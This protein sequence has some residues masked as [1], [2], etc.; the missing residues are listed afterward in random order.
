MYLRPGKFFRNQILLDCLGRWRNQSCQIFFQSV[1]SDVF[2]KGS[3]FAIFSVNH[4]WPLQ[5]LYYRTTV[6][7]SKRRLFNC[8]CCC[9]CLQAIVCWWEMTLN[10]ILTIT[11]RGR[12]NETYTGHISLPNKNKEMPSFMH[13]PY[14]PAQA[15]GVLENGTQSQ[16]SRFGELLPDPLV[17]AQSSADPTGESYFVVAV[18]LVYSMSVVMLIA[19]RIRRRRAKM[20]VDHQIDKYLREFQIVKEK[21]SRD[22]Y[23]NLKRAVIAKLSRDKAQT[24][25][26]SRTETQL[27]SAAT[28]NGLEPQICSTRIGL[29]PQIC[30][31]QNGLEPPIRS[32]RIGAEP[33]ICSIRNG[34]EPQICSTRN[35]LELPIRST[36]IGLEPQIC[37]TRNGLES[38]IRS[39]RLEPQLCSTRIGMG[40]FVLPMSVISFGPQLTNSNGAIEINCSEDRTQEFSSARLDCLRG[41]DTPLNGRINLLVWKHCIYCK[42]Y[43]SSDLIIL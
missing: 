1:H 11:F 32:T 42:F 22:S 8:V 2:G 27:C 16:P 14:H 34:L 24:L 13:T 7:E 9:C 40:S 10:Q 26:A 28:R 21:S 43:T 38:P 18:C 37:S 12:D 35:G 29:E 23:R 41:F 30:S 3:N 36:R 33:Q 39:T 31:T 5:L 15:A 17:T 25:C 20:A 4:G 19:S 6:I